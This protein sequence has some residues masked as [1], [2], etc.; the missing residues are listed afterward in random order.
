MADTQARQRATDLKE[1][2]VK[3]GHNK[4]RLLFKIRDFTEDDVVTENVK[5]IEAMLKEIREE[6]VS[7]AVNIQGVIG[8]FRTELGETKISQWEGATWFLLNLYNICSLN[9]TRS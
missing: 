6:H 8:V 4:E 1:L 2:E 5:H 7:I 9:F 3:L